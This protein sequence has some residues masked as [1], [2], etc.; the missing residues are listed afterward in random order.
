MRQ[1]I[2]DAGRL[3][4]Q[5]TGWH[6]HR[7]HWN[8]YGDSTVGW[9]S[10]LPDPAPVWSAP[11]EEGAEGNVH[12]PDPKRERGEAALFVNLGVESHGSQR[13]LEAFT[14]GRGDPSVNHLIHRHLTR[15]LLFAAEDLDRLFPVD[16]LLPHLQNQS[17][18]NSQNKEIWCSA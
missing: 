5:S 4:H 15:Q 18:G 2:S 3:R 10:D 17:N 6:S 1:R 9:G 16:A 12:Q 7:S 11:Q 14:L 8:A 13:D